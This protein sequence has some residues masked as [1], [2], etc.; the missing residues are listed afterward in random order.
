MNFNSS[1]HSFLVY[2]CDC[3]NCDFS[4]NY[5]RGIGFLLIT[6][7]DKKIVE[8]IFE[9]YSFLQLTLFDN[10]NSGF[11]RL[12]SRN[13]FLEYH[14]T[15][16]IRSIKSQNII[17][18]KTMFEESLLLLTV[19]WAQLNGSTVNVIIRLQKS[20]VEVLKLFCMAALKKYF[21]IFRP[22]YYSEI[23]TFIIRYIIVISLLLWYYQLQNSL[24]S[25]FS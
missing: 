13:T 23:I 9:K 7:L 20:N 18:S 14:E 24:Q 11:I 17:F 4:I 6:H 2:W 15:L 12:K 21:Q 10:S 22:L 19:P 1:S 3:S 5:S 8:Q 25:H 16:E